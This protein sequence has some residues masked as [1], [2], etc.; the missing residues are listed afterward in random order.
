[1]GREEIVQRRINRGPDPSI[2]GAEGG[3]YLSYVRRIC[4]QINWAPIDY[5]NVLDSVGP[6]SSICLRAEEQ[7]RTGREER[8]EENRDTRG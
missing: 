8:T 2:C 6:D 1:M 4:R 3:R 5:P 7:S